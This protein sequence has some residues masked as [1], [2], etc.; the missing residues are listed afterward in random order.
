MWKSIGCIYLVRV[1][2]RRNQSVKQAVAGGEARRSLTGSR[3]DQWKLTGCLPGGSIDAK[4][5]MAD[6]KQTEKK[7]HSGSEFSLFPE[8]DPNSA[9]L[10]AEEVRSLV[11]RGELITGSTFD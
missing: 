10:T 5:K 11:A 3:S 1:C 6:Q 8:L 7:A 2:S 4:G 9:I